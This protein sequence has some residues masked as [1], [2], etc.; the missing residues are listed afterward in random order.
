MRAAGD[1]GE[2]ERQRPRL[3]GGWRSFSGR[4]LHHW[5]EINAHFGASQLWGAMVGVLSMVGRRKPAVSVSNYSEA[6][7]QM[8]GLRSCGIEHLAVAFPQGDS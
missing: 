2:D 1:V 3:A 4:W 5:R 8:V 6:A 7:D